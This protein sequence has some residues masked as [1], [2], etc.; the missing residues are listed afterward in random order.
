[1]FSK[2]RKCFGVRV[3]LSVSLIGL[4]CTNALQAQQSVDTTRHSTLNEVIVTATKPRFSVIS[5]MPVQ[6]LSGKNIERLSSYSVADAIRYFSGV[7]LK[8]YGGIGGLKTINVRSLCECLRW[9]GSDRS[10]YC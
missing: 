2:K 5:P 3:F 8:D 10:K 7:Q 1:M 6:T 4:S 9:I